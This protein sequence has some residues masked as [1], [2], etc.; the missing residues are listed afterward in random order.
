MD[1]TG[2]DT[3]RLDSLRAC[4]HHLDLFNASDLGASRDS[5]SRQSHLLEVWP[6]REWRDII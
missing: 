5:L 3:T 1:W 2:L 4:V 6:L